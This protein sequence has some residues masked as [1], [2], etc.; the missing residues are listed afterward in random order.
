MC[1]ARDLDTAREHCLLVR[2]LD[3]AQGGEGRRHVDERHVHKPIAGLSRELALRPERLLR[4]R[5]RGQ[6]KRDLR[7]ASADRAKKF[8]VL[9][10]RERRLA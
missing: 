9:G 5:G 10:I 8:G 4:L 1:F 7:V 3:L 6:P 2:R